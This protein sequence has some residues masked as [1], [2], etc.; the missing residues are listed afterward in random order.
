MN[1]WHA[2][3]WS[4][5]RNTRTA[6]MRLYGLNVTMPEQLAC[7]CV[8]CISQYTNSW[9]AVVWSERHNARTAGMELNGLNVT[10]HEQLACNCVV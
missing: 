4:E 6:G 10:T 2:N 8:V 1:S 7:N 9:H 5:Y 3:V